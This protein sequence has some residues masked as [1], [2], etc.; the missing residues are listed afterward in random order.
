MLLL[1]VYRLSKNEWQRLSLLITY[2]RNTIQF[3]AELCKHAQ[4][5]VIYNK[6]YIHSKLCMYVV[7]LGSIPVFYYTTIS[8]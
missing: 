7:M 5:V 2:I 6:L 1:C 3:P 8:L 4:D